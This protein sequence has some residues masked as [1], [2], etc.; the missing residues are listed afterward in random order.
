MLHH[1]RTPV[2][3]SMTTNMDCL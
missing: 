1:L 2:C 3:A